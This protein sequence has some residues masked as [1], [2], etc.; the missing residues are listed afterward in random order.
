[1]V[2]SS[3]GTRVVSFQPELISHALNVTKRTPVSHRS[4]TECSPPTGSFLQAG[5]LE[6]MF[7]GGTR[8]QFEQMMRDM[9]HGGDKSPGPEEFRDLDQKDD[10]DDPQ[11]RPEA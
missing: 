11:Q 4:E 5:K 1:M 8:E 6:E 10:P 2:I 7:G 3:K 9:G